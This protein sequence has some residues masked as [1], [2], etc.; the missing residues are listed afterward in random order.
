MSMSMS[1]MVL[2]PICR[3]L[4]EEIVN[5]DLTVSSVDTAVLVSSIWLDN[6]GMN[7][8]MVLILHS[9]SSNVAHA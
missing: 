2:I 4:Y 6:P 8:A 5:D 7:P 3:L 9:N 1:S